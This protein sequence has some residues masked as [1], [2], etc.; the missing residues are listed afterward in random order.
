M[1]GYS[2]DW[3]SPVSWC[4]GRIDVRRDR[5]VEHKRRQI[6]SPSTGLGTD[7]RT[8]LGESP[9]TG[10]GAG[11]KGVILSERKREKS[12]NWC[13]LVHFGAF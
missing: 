6:A 9:S 2:T 8:K 10:L 5:E 11:N 7:W 4:E 12:K 3:Y 13:V 1:F